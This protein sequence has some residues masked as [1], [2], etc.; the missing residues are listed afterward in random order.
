MVETAEKNL[1]SAGIRAM[2]EVTAN[3]YSHA[4]RE[5]TGY[6]RAYDADVIVIGSHGRGDL[7][8][9][10]GGSTAHKVV[11]MADRPVVVVPDAR[12]THARRSRCDRS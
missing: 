8:A 3:L 2:S 9:L 6:A 5:I 12:H 10:I 7:T 1:A 11:H 4:A